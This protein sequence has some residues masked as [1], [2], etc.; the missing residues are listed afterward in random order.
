MR[1]YTGGGDRG[2]TSLFSGERMSKAHARIEA[3]GEVDELNS[4]V[5]VLVGLLPEGQ[6]ELAAELQRI[7]G[8]L[9]LVGARLATIP[10]S[11]SL[12]MLPPLTAEHTAELEQ[13]IDRMQDCLPPL[14]SFILPGGS[15]AAAWAHVARTVC[16]RAERRV[17][18]LAGD[19]AE[20][21]AVLVYLNRLS[22]YFFVLARTCNRLV[23]VPDVP[24][25]G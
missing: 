1:I 15:S 6:D 20:R 10:G 19:E 5:G 23:G 25:S 22:D 14:R 24:W 12:D 8:E 13:A 4:V 7:Q 11:P 21:D 9:F 17:V 2:K 3:Y 16:R 18:R